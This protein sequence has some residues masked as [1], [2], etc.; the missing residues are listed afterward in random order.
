[1]KGTYLVL[2]SL[3][4]VFVAACVSPSAAKKLS[5]D[6]VRRIEIGYQELAWMRLSIV[7]AVDS[8]SCDIDLHDG[9]GFRKGS[10]LSESERKQFINV[11]TSIVNA[12]DPSYQNTAPPSGGSQIYHIKVESPERAEEI[13]LDPVTS[14]QKLIALLSDLDSRIQDVRRRAGVSPKE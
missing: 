4:V 14:P 13:H 11:T 9:K 10:R 5:S 2:G 3:A 7:I 1:M 8:Q 12:Y 6:S